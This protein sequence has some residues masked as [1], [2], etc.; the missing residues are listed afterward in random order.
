MDHEAFGSVS[1]LP[2]WFPAGLSGV[3]KPTPSE[4]DALQTTSLSGVPTGPVFKCVS[5]L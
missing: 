3:M 4:S 2:G 5:L 1:P